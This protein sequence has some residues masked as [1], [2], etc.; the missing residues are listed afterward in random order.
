MTAEDDE[1]DNICRMPKLT[2][3]NDANRFAFKRL[4]PLNC[5]G[6]V[7]FFIDESS[8]SLRVNE[9]VLRGRKLSKCVFT[10][11]VW[12]DDYNYELLEQIIVT[13]EPF[14]TNIPHDF[15]RVQCYLAVSNSGRKLLTD[16]ALFDGNVDA[17][18][19]PGFVG[20]V[21]LPDMPQAMFERD[22]NDGHAENATHDNPDANIAGKEKNVD[23]ENEFDDEYEA[24]L[25]DLAYE[26][27]DASEEDNRKT[28]LAR[29]SNYR[30]YYPEGGRLGC[31]DADFD[32]YIA[33]V[34]INSDVTERVSSTTARR[35]SLQMNVLIFAM[36]SMSH[37][38]Y[39]RLLPLTYSF[40]RDHLGAVILNGY[41]IV[42]DATISALLPILTGEFI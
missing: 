31:N 12:L 37:L 32:Q 19:L 7:L 25:L 13:E 20:S 22:T 30:V 34:S 14:F 5:A 38:S 10:P 39:Q 4:P 26:E 33:Q 42:G 27:P 29:D 1:R 9:T 3:Q 6:D 35:N 18:Q 2:L 8:R 28:G 11:I 17:H 40:L 16:E 21:G 23:D 41:N 15:F 36:D 24:Q